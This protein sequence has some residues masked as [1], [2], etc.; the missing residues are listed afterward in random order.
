MEEADL[1]D[2]GGGVGVG[3][4]HFLDL[5]KE[6]RDGGGA[7]AIGPPPPPLSLPSLGIIRSNALSTDG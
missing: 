2:C 7:L 6:P 3:K 1:G 4:S 5:R